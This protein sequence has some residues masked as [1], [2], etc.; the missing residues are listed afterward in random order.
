VLSATAFVFYGVLPGM[1]V[2]AS[3]LVS[4]VGFILHCLM[5]A[6]RQ[7]ENATMSADSAADE[8]ARPVDFHSAGC[9]VRPEKSGYWDN[10]GV[11]M[12]LL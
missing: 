12:W 8:K 5:A 7:L 6:K 1:C 3:G 10:N 9:V 2:F 4:V 11:L